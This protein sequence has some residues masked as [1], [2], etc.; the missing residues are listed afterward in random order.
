MKPPLI[1]DPTLRDPRYALGDDQAT[2]AMRLLYPG[3]ENTIVKAKKLLNNL[4]YGKQSQSITKDAK[5][6]QN[7]ASELRIQPTQKKRA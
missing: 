5:V 6:L 3:T 2:S 7:S 1:A 4:N